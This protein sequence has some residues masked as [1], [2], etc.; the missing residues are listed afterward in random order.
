MEVAQREPQARIGALSISSDC[1][2]WDVECLDSL[3][4]EAMRYIAHWDMN[5]GKED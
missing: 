1:R 3:V 4:F 5:W 2:V